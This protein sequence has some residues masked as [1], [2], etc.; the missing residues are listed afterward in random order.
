MVLCNVV[1]IILVEL[2]HG[3]DHVIEA[4]EEEHEHITR[5]AGADQRVV[6]MSSCPPVVREPPFLGDSW[7]DYDTHHTVQVVT[8]EGV[9]SGAILLLLPWHRFVAARQFLRPVPIVPVLR[10][11]LSLVGTEVDVLV[12]LKQK[13]CGGGAH[14]CTGGRIINSTCMGRG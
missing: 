1:R 6:V 10:G 5:H 13:T 4:R 12:G 8:V 3:G 14:W 7:D 9:N 11:R 2:A